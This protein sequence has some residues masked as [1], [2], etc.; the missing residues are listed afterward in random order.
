[1]TELLHVVSKLGAVLGATGGL[2][3]LLGIGADK[4]MG[5]HGLK[6]NPPSP[7]AQ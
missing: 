1:M 5:F 2:A 7:L 3:V 4:E 6:S